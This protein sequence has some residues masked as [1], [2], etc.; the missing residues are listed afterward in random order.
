MDQFYQRQANVYRSVQSKLCRIGEENVK[1]SDDM[2]TEHYATSDM[3]RNDLA[4]IRG[5][6]RNRIRRL[7]SFRS[8]N[9]TD[10]I[11]KEVA[12]LLRVNVNTVR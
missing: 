6:V 5:V 2:H 11:A 8:R 7:L 1:T 12:N 4:K 3:E 10:L 9:S